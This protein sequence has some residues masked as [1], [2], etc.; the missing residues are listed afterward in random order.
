MSK[1]TSQS[2]RSNIVLTN[3]VLIQQPSGIQHNE[4]LKSLQEKQLKISA[5]INQLSSRI[6]QSSVQIPNYQKLNYNPSPLSFQVYQPS[7]SNFIKYNILFKNKSNNSTF[8]LY[9]G[10]GIRKYFASHIIVFDK[11]W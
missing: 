2:P 6:D 1:S 8:N 3:S 11:I 10:L 9:T 7:P 4:M 5:D